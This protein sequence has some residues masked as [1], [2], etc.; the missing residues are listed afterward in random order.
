[1]HWRLRGRVIDPIEPQKFSKTN[2][3]REM[4][5]EQEQAIREQMTRKVAYFI[6]EH[7]G[8][9]KGKDLEHWL[10]AEAEI[11]QQFPRSW[12]EAQCH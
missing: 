6:W 3:A 8:R 4:L 9:P 5:R 12:A 10:K 1:M 11:R 2:G 7:A